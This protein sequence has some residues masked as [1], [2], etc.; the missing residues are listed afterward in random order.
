MLPRFLQ[1][2]SNIWD[3]LPILVQ[4]NQDRLLR[5]T[6]YLTADPLSWG[7]LMSNGVYEACLTFSGPA[8]WTLSACPC[9]CSIYM[10]CLFNDAQLKPFEASGCDLTFLDSFLT[11]A[12]SQ[13]GATGAVKRGSL[14]VLLISFNSHSH[15]VLHPVGI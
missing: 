12:S 10:A 14:Y 8:I 11:T 9:S 13:R 7:T 2:I 1:G 4:A 6:E 15:R 5:C 3:V